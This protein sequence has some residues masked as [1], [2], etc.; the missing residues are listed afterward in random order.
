MDSQA[1]RAREAS[2]LPGG[3]GDALPPTAAATAV[4][5]PAVDELNGAALVA[6]CR[7]GDMAAA[8]AALK[9]GA[10]SHYQE[11]ATGTSGLMAAA[12]ANQ[13]EL[14]ELMLQRGAPWNAVDRKGKCAGQYALAAGHQA[15]VD[16]LVNAGVQ[17][18]L[19]FRAMAKK[20]PAES[21]E[22]RIANK[23]Y[24]EREIK[25]DGDRLLDEEARGVM[26]QWEAP[27]M[28][29]HAE[30]IC[31]GSGDVLNVGFG[32]GIID[33]YIQTYAP[34][35]HTI[36]EAHPDVYKKMLAEG[37]G[38][39]PGVKIVFG[40]W[41]D[42]INDVGPFDGIFF[43]TFDD[44]FVSFHSHLPR[45]LKS[46]GIYS[47]FNGIHPENTFFQGVA[48]QLITTELE[49]YGFASEYITCAID[50]EEDK[51]Q[52]GGITF[53]YFE[54]NSYY[55]PIITWGPGQPAPEA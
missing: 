54:G 10:E 33:T 8:R 7:I 43:D 20:K 45:L 24:L 26:M 23:K 15:L 35:S 40:R 5:G 30:V 34:R 27:L 3:I 42:V 6:A 14:V 1:G 21:N 55:L 36:I 29:A 4:D 11:V 2:P 22:E 9:A 12:G 28:A 13:A 46:G 17:A 48:C 18:E 31:R 50:C 25:Y 53:R 49:G 19:L 51:E 39:K 38:D 41:E 32:M 44:D 37:W 52:W 47:Y 16:R